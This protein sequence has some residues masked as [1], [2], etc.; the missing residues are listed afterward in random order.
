[1]YY[2]VLSLIRAPTIRAQTAKI[3]MFILFTKAPRLGFAKQRCQTFLEERE[4]LT[5]AQELISST[6]RCLDETGLPYVIHY[7][8]D[9]RDFD[10]LETSNKAGFIKQAAGDLGQRMKA[11]LAYEASR[12]TNNEPLILLGSDLIGL[13]SQEL[14][15]LDHLYR[16]ASKA[17]HIVSLAPCKDG[18][19]GLIGMNSALLSGTVAQT[20]ILVKI[21]LHMQWSHASV[22]KQLSQRIFEQDLELYIPFKL[23]DI[24]YIEDLLS[25]ELGQLPVSMHEGSYCWIIELSDT[26]AILI[27]KYNFCSLNPQELLDQ[28]AIIS[29]LVRS[30]QWR[31]HGVVGYRPG[32]ESD[33]NDSRGFKPRLM[34]RP[35]YELRQ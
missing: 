24:D 3:S 11:A 12:S 19:F 26:R 14:I 29:A 35:M 22:F 21:F 27:P 15:K 7:A 18:G 25:Y 33:L 16:N 23:N 5:L 17:N 20:E 31:L 34:R 9:I 30:Q 32:Y 4:A 28:D 2:I 8:G 10:F 1:M 13:K 6:L